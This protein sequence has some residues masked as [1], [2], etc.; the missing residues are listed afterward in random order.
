MPSARAAFHEEFLNVPGPNW[1]QSRRVWSLA[2]ALYNDRRTVEARVGRAVEY[3]MAANT[4]SYAEA[5]TALDRLNT[6]A[7]PFTVLDG[8]LFGLASTSG[9]GRAYALL[10]RGDAERQATRLNVAVGQYRARYG[11]YPTV[12]AELV[13]DFIGAVPP[14]PFGAPS[15][16]YRLE[17]PD[18]YVLWSLGIDGEDDGGEAGLGRSGQTIAFSDGGDDIYTFPRGEPTDEPELVPIE[19][20]DA[21]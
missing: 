6:S 21:P 12:L 11:R 4:L 2:S 10:T 7:S 9:Y 15:F 17:E 5:V 19:E 18:R 16:G 1:L 13:P 8:R 3:V 14:E 20:D